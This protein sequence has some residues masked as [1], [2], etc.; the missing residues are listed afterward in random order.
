MGF[1]SYLINGAVFAVT[2]VIV[3]AV[4]FALAAAGLFALAWVV[5]KALH[6]TGTL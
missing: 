4:R 5:I 6:Y 1:F 3:L 2:F